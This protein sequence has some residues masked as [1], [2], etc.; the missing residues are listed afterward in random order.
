MTLHGIHIP[1]DRIAEFCRRHGIRRLAFFGSILRD[2]FTRES[3]IDL[4]VEFEPSQPVGLLRLTAIELELA[5]LLGRKVDLST[6]GSLSPY[7]RD[8]VLKEARTL[9]VAA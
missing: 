6:A 8:D 2:D 9:Y 5:D 3:D 4:L 7:F 1:E